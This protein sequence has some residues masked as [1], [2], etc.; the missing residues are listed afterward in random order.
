MSKPGDIVWADGRSWQKYIPLR[1]TKKCWNDGTDQDMS[2]KDL[3]SFVDFRWLIK[4]RKNISAISYCVDCGVE[5]NLYE[6][7]RQNCASCYFLTDPQF[8]EGY[9]VGA[10]KT[11]DMMS[12]TCE[13]H[14]KIETADAYE[15]GFAN[16]LKKQKEQN[17]YSKKS[18]KIKYNKS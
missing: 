15:A 16:G 13:E 7:F 11:F 4:D 2:V 14:R 12:Q 8:L 9:Q 5:I 6:S 18:N 3:K 17:F 10:D 1:K